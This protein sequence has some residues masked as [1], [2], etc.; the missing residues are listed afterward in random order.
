MKF[1]Y[2]MTVYPFQ[3]DDRGPN[4]PYVSAMPPAEM[5][6]EGAKVLTFDV[7]V[8]DDLFGIVKTEAIGPT[9]A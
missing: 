6:R 5:P 8:P 7:E 9:S 2:W 4:K 3:L 1:R